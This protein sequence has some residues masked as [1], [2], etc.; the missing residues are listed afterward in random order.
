VR[1]DAVRDAGARL[2]EVVIGFCRDLVRIPSFSGDEGAAAER[3]ADELR[4]LGLDE[5]TI[6]RAGNVLGV[7]HANASD[8]IEGAVLLNAHL[9]VV[10][11]DEA[12]DWPHPPFEGVVADGRLWGRGSTDTKSAVAAQVHAA[13]LLARLQR[14][15]SLTRRRDLVVAAV[16]QEEV[17]GLG[18]AALLEER[19][20]DYRAAVIGEPSE[21]ALSFGHRGRVEVRVRFHGRAAH[22]S[23]PDWGLNP[24]GSLARFV[25]SLPSLGHDAD[26]RFGSSSVSPTLVWARPES[27]N[28]I[29]SVVELVLDWRNVPAES[30]EAVR[31]RVRALAQD[32]A[33][34][35][36]RVEVLTPR[37]DLCS[38]RGERREL[39]LVSRPFGTD[40]DGE[41]F[42]RARTALEAG[43]GRDVPAIAWDFASDGG[44]LEAAGVPCIGFGPGRM[45][46]MHAVGESCELDLLAEAVAGYAFLALALDDA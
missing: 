6:D 39:E 23:R 5:V 20:A 4:R 44:W 32:A 45:D 17:G 2:R 30:P 42:R 36:V 34:A 9:D 21:G 41:L 7:L 43:L 28:V 10:G 3:T 40:P 15:G 19:G 18:T 25:S 33:E 11:V 13:G 26:E 14:E 1:P 35:G 31:A 16:V 46:V 29:P 12:A 22:A 38:W 37:L 24:H 27:V 8:R